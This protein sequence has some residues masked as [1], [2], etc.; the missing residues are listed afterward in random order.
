MAV[1]PDYTITPRPRWDKWSPIEQAYPVYLRIKLPHI[2]EF[3]EQTNVYITARNQW[4]K[5]ARKVK[6]HQNM[7]DLNKILDN[8]KNA[9][10]A[11]LL[12]HC[13]Q[14]RELTKASLGRKEIT[15]FFDYV[16]NVVS[17]KKATT[18]IGRI[19][20]YMKREPS[21]YEINYEWLRKYEK[22]QK[23][24]WE[25]APETINGTFR[26]LR[27]I[28]NTAFKEGYIPKKLIGKDLY[29]VPKGGSEDPTFLIEEEREVL[30]N[31]W[32][33]GKIEDESLYKTLTYFLLACYSGLRFGD[34]E[35][36]D[37]KT[38]TVGDQISLRAQKNGNM[39]NY[40]FTKSL[41][42]IIAVIRKIGPLG[43]SYDLYNNK[44]LKTLQAYFAKKE[45]GGIDKDWGRSHVGR[46]SFGRL[47]AENN[48][49]PDDCA[50]FMGISK[51]TVLIYY[52]TSGKIVADRNKHLKAV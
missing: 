15:S 35:V 47:M 38:K 25:D 3:F 52:H 18:E 19:M 49:T 22:E 51:T 13:A 50:Y 26:V 27:K 6:N 4:N 44:N 23:E 14:G 45:N 24:K 9:I 20:R 37:I 42:A 29:P 2:P 21:I 32:R 8:Q 11:I 33:K 34:L 12:E 31:A 36:F 39:V 5:P 10:D 43:Q 1:K 40:P 46:H 48:V 41:D 16:K 7:A 30:F 17:K 28:T